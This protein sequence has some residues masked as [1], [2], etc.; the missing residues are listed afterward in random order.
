MEQDAY[1][2]TASMSNFIFT[3]VMKVWVKPS[4]LV[5]KF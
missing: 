3:V 1:K 4:V 5:S 2:S